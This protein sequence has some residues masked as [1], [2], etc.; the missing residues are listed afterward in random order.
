MKHLQLFL[1]LFLFCWR[2]PAIAQENPYE[3]LGI[4]TKVL[5]LSN[6][7]YQEFF[8]NDTLVPIGNVMLNT[9]TGEV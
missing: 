5:T 1:F 3:S 4:E 7:K 2:L 8:P 6:G 9:I